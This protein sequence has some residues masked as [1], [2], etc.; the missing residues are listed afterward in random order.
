MAAQVIPK[1]IHRIWVGGEEPG[2]LQN[3]GK[4]WVEH[5]PDWEIRQWHDGNVSDLFPLENQDLYDRAEQIAP[6]HVG[7]L[8]ADVLRYELLWRHGGMYVDA[9][10]EC[11]RPIDDLLDGVE[12]FAAWEVQNVWIANGLMGAVPQHP[13]VRRL[14]DGAG[15]SIESQPG[16][17]VTRLTGPQYLT[18]LYRQDDCGMTVFPTKLFYPYLYDKIRR[19]GT[20]HRGDW[21]AQGYYAVHHWNNRRKERGLSHHGRRK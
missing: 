13:M 12:C 8:R 16:E 1:I 11:L 5:H 4:T 15:A 14:I 19:F 21:H 9:D 7:Q 20:S 6:D 10:F 18:G 17:R 3:C 2:W